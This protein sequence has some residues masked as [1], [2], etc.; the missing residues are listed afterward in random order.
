M[1]APAKNFTNPTGVGFSFLLS[2]QHR[3]TLPPSGNLI[4]AVIATTTEMWSKSMVNPSVGI[5][6]SIPKVQKRLSQSSVVLASTF[7]F[8]Y[9][10]TKE[11]LAHG[12]RPLAGQLWPRGNK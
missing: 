2:P 8:V 3:Q 12:G 6:L 4:V 11:I 5:T 10:T 1:A 7:P 9:K